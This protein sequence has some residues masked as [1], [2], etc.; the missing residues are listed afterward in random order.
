LKPLP[1]KANPSKGGD[2]KPK[3]LMTKVDD[4]RV[5]EEEDLS[6]C[7]FLYGP[8]LIKEDMLMSVSKD[9]MGV[10]KTKIFILLLLFLFNA[11]PAGAF[12]SA[13]NVNIDTG[14]IDRGI[15][16]IAYLNDS[17]EKI[18]VMIQ[19]DTQKYTYD[20]KAD[21]SRQSFP[22]QLGNGDYTI[23][24]LQNTQGT[25]Y[26]YLKTEKVSLKLEDQRSVYLNSIQ[27]IDLGNTVAADKAKKLT[28]GLT[29][30]KSKVEAI[31]NYIVNNYS[32]DYEKAKTVQTGY[33]P[34]I[35]DTLYTKK[36]ICYDYAS[37]F[38]SMTRSV[39]IPCKLVKGYTDDVN[40]YH[41]WNEV[42][43][44]GKWI[45]VDTAS[46]MQRRATGIKYTMEKPAAS[47]MKKYEY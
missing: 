12:A 16:H 41:A 47:F 6:I 27:S 3:G 4:S 39:G 30:D 21:G 24:V 9:R 2:A 20:M 36:G 5:A 32:Y 31:Y 29:T 42:S 37:L 35:N 45:V 1:I 14:S 28:Q 44:N 22:L 25:K 13:N 34:D 11:F 15:V 33:I 23:S 17:P 18:K 43:V 26:K 10:L 46:D 40:G 7:L 38:A 19:K 8:S